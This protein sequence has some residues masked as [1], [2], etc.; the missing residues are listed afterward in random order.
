MLSLIVCSKSPQRLDALT[1]NVEAT[2]GCTH[3]WVVINNTSG[4]HTLFSAYN[5][6]VK[7]SHGDHL[8][9]LHEDL[10]FHT[11]SWGEL[12][13]RH[14]SDP[15]CG[16]AGVSGGSLMPRVPA[17][18]SAYDAIKYFIQSEKEEQGGTFITNGHFNDKNYKEV[19][20][21]DGLFLAANKTMFTQLRFDEETFNGFHMYDIDICLQAHVLGYRNRV[22]NNILIEHFSK[23][24]TNRQWV[25]NSRL[26]NKKWG[27]S[28]PLYITHP[29]QKQLEKCEQHYLLKVYMKR[30]IRASY[31]T[32]EI[33]DLMLSSLSHIKSTRNVAFRW[34]VRGLIYW[35]R[36]LKQPQTL[37]PFFRHA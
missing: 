8:C 22:I 28:L 12:L 33:Q 30:M 21:L 3:E 2:V 4:K 24:T 18:W 9:F 7:Q 10:H 32:D 14:L 13:I 35:R 27:Q 6:G 34:Y 19:V 16:F 17:S 25:E 15:T 5:L 20:A 29:G 11:E 37:I 26:L 31:D 36:L 1:H 23:G